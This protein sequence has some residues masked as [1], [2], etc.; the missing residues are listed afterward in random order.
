MRKQISRMLVGALLAL[1]LTAPMAV[2]AQEAVGDGAKTTAV[3]VKISGIMRNDT[4]GHNVVVDTQGRLYTAEQFPGYDQNMT[5]RNV[6]VNASLAAGIGD[7]NVTPLDTH[8]MRLGTLLIQATPLSVT[9]AD[10][11]N[12][13]RLGFEIRSNLDGNVDS[14]STFGFYMYGRSDQ[15]AA[16]AAASQIDT[17]AVGQLFNAV[18][19]TASENSTYSGEFVVAVAINRIGCGPSANGTMGQ[20]TFSYPNGIAIPLSSIF[21]RDIYSPYTT[22]RVRNL[23]TSGATPTNRSVR[24]T[25]H[26]VGTPL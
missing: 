6:I 25:V 19:L 3:G 8:R 23:G 15:G 22:I 21:G 4:T 18:N 10:S 13:V 9:G 12:I 17:S 16:V 14:L 1:G 26:L 2:H 20:R 24:L 7:S 5:F 11:L